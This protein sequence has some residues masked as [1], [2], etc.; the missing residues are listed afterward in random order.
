MRKFFGLKPVRR[1]FRV[2]AFALGTGLSF[3]GAGNVFG[4]GALESALFGALGA[5]IGLISALAFGFASKGEVP[6]QD[7]DRAIN[8]ALSQ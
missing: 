2:L 8:D 4:I 5:I 7:F 1:L 3:M 6:D